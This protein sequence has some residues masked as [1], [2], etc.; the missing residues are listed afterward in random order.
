MKSLILTAIL[1]LFFIGVANSDEPSSPSPAFAV[2]SFGNNVGK[3]QWQKPKPKPQ[4]PKVILSTNSNYNRPTQNNYNT[5]PRIIY[6]YNYKPN[7]YQYN[8][9]N[10]YHY[11]SRANF[12]HQQRMRGNGFGGFLINIRL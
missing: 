6:Q 9:Y 1:S 7:F 11:R 4:T 2:R 5:Q 8:Y 10:S 12:Y 3:Q